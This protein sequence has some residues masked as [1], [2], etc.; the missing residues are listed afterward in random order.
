MTDKNKTTVGDEIEAELGTKKQASKPKPKTKEYY[1]VRVE[2]LAPSV[3]TYR[4]YAES[5]EEAVEI[6]LKQRGQQ[7]SAPPSIIFGRMKN[8]KATVYAAGSSLVKYVKNL[9]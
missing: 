7:M 6:A 9:A 2:V 4:I 5:P 3:L 8:L 1:T